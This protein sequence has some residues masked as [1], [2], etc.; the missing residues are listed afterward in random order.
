[1]NNINRDVYFMESNHD[2]EMLMHGPYPEWWQLP[3]PKGCWIPS[4]F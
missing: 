1:M 3:L 2:I 4:G